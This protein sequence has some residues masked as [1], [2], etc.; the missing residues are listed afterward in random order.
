MSKIPPDMQLMGAD[1]LLNQAEMLEKEFRQIFS[2]G[3]GL[4]RKRNPICINN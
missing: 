2:N 3:K 1:T 4:N